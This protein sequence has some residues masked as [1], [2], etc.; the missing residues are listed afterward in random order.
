[1]TLEIEVQKLRA[2]ASYLRKELA[3]R[4]NAWLKQKQKGNKL[5]EQLKEKDRKIKELEQKLK[6]VTEENDKLNGLLHSAELHTNKLSGQL[7][8]SA[9]SNKPPSGR[10]IGG[11]LGHKGI[12]RK[13]PTL[14]HIDQEKEIYLSHCPSCDTR[15]EQSTNTYNRIVTDIPQVTSVVTKY[16][17]QRQWCVG[18][19]KEVT[20]NPKDTISHS[21]FG[22]NLV[23]LVLFVKY[24]MRLPLQKIQELLLVQYHLRLSAAALQKIIY[25][26]HKWLGPSYKKILKAIKKAPV[27]HA[28]ETSWKISGQNGWAWI[29]TTLKEVYYS[30]EPTRG[31]AVIEKTL[32]ASFTG[33]LVHDDYLAYQK[34]DG[35]HASCW[36]HLLRI[37]DD[38]AG[39]KNPAAE[40]LDL[41]VAMEQ[42][43]VDLK[44]FKEQG[45]N[46][47]PIDRSKLYTQY[48]DKLIDITKR[49]YKEKD[50]LA[51]QTR[52]N[53]QQGNLLI[54]ILYPE[55][56]LTNNHAERQLRPLVIIRKISGSSRSD[57]GAAA[58]AVNMSVVQTLSL[59]GKNVFTGLRQILTST[60]GMRYVL[61]KGE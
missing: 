41:K 1:M 32:G 9:R 26:S 3:T 59:Q 27:K 23:L 24:R 52:I 11:Q 53:N 36:S 22:L 12:S 17:I 44:N 13:R 29:L 57:Q 58:T 30:L 35:R 6:Q 5:E 25:R 14:K 56:P 19:K 43:F 60:I 49:P 42:I 21:P 39:L 33:T 61:E 2:E 47:L 45:S 18:C 48:L 54:S 8:K 37:L 38:Y 4:L 55:V 7:F 31:K 16:N 10:T 46:L 34:L 51:V 20:A 28:D 40:L 50:A 15:L